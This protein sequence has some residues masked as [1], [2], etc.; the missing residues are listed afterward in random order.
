MDK[1][2]R[3]LEQIIRNPNRAPNSF[4]DSTRCETVSRLSRVDLL[5]LVGAPV[6]VSDIPDVEKGEVL[7]DSRGMGSFQRLEK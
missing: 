4:H 1:A 6:Q 3:I 5:G 7:T 2:A